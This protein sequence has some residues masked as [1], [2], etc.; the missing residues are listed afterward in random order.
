MRKP[1]QRRAS[2]SPPYHRLTAIVMTVQRKRDTVSVKKGI[3]IETKTSFQLHKRS[4]NP[5]PTTIATKS[6]V[7]CLAAVVQITRYRQ[8]PFTPSAL[9]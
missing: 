3:V 7:K 6:A 9:C 4:G 5:L 2:C 8:P 1:H